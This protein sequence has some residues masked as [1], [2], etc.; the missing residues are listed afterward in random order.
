[1]LRVCICNVVVQR[2][3]AEES[4]IPSTTASQS[5]PARH[6]HS[7]LAVTTSLPYCGVTG[8]RAVGPSV[9]GPDRATLWQNELGDSV[10]VLSKSS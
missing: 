6:V 3:S 5:E 1:M 8:A 2:A 4:V 7:G 9:Q 10:C